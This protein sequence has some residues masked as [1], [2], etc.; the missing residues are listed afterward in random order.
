MASMLKNPSPVPAYMVLW[1]VGSM[2]SELTLMLGIRSATGFHE[3]AP[4]AL[5]QIPPPTPPAYMI[6]GEVGSISMARVLPPTL[7]G[8]RLVHE[9]R[10][11][12]ST[13]PFFRPSLSDGKR[14]PVAVE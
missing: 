12:G 11:S 2:T 10:N 4:S 5:F 1:F 8:P 9:P 7:P 3:A 14:A 6:L 13:S